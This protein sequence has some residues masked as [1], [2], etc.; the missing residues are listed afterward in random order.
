MRSDDRN[1]RFD[2]IEFA[3][4]SPEDLAQ[5]RD[6]LAAVFGWTYKQW[7]DG[8]ADTEDSGVVSGISAESGASPV[9][10]PVV[11]SADLEALRDRIRSAG[12][13]I[14]RDIFSF[15]GGRRFH[16]REP[17]GNEMAAWAETEDGNPAGSL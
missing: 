1:D 4:D 10:L 16:F 17:S 2:Y 11:Y 13:E 9:P 5:T 3:T 7:G 15:P 14:T 12:G 6:F 8:Y